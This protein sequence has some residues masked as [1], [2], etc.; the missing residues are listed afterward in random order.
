[1]SHAEHRNMRS[2]MRNH[3]DNLDRQLRSVMDPDQVKRHDEFS[4]IS[5]KPKPINKVCL[6]SWLV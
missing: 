5:I 1:M 3:A 4:M 2:T 6:Q